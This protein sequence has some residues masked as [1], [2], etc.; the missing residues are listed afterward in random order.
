MDEKSLLE[1]GG[2]YRD[3]VKMT[4][5]IVRLSAVGKRGIRGMFCAWNGRGG[6]MKGSAKTNRLNEQRKEGGDHDKNV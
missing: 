1:G 3:C 6:R 5:D 2:R 4:D